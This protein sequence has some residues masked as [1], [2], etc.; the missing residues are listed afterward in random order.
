MSEGHKHHYVPAFYQRLFADSAGL[1]WVYDRRRK[2]FQ[3]LNPRSICSQTD[4]YAIKRE[5]EPRNRII[6]SDVLSKIDDMGATSIRD[7]VSGK[8]DAVT[9]GTLAYFVGV[10]YCRLPTMARVMSSVWELGL[11]EMIRLTAVKT[12]RMQSSIDRYERATGKSLNVSAEDM[13]AAVKSDGIEVVVTE[14]PFLKSLFRHAT[15]IATAIGELG[16]EV[17]CASDSTGFIT[18]DDPVVVVPPRG[19]SDVGMMIRGAVTYFPLCRRMCL[20]F[21][22]ASGAITDRNVDTDAVCT[23]NLNI[24]PNSERF[25]MGPDRTQLESVVFRS[26]SAECDSEPRVGVTTVESDDDSTTAMMRIRPTRYF[27]GS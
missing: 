4:L 13:I 19:G 3:H 20:R 9:V 12:E 24:A 11:R 22:G 17:L 16:W 10:Q 25:V 7:F 23:V 15:T 1:L 6:E 2:T 27:Y 26:G 18:C 8:R 5:G 21:A 14:K